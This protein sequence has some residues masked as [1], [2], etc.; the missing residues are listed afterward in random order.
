MI[1]LLFAVFSVPF[2]SL[3]VFLSLL[4]T[5]LIWI[6]KGM[7]YLHF[8]NPVR[9]GELCILRAALT[10]AFRSSMEV[11]VEVWGEDPFTAERRFCCACFLTFVRLVPRH[12]SLSLSID[13]GG[14]QD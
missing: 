14:G 1:A 7:D 3:S 13:R 8:H 2:L 12:P 10:R 11:E 4:S 6:S 5:F 9:L